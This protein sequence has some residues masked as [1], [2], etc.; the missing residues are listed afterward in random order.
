[1]LGESSHIHVEENTEDFVGNVGDGE[2]PAQSA[3]YTGFSLDAFTIEDPEGGADISGPA[4]SN[5][6]GIFLTS[7]SAQIEQSNTTGGF[8]WTA[9]TGGDADLSQILEEARSIH[10]VTNDVNSIEFDFTVDAGIVAVGADFVFGT[11]EYPEFTEYTDI[12]GFIV[13]G[14][15]YARF[16]DG[17]LVSF[18]EEGA[19]AN[20]INNDAGGY[21]IEYDGVSLQLRVCAPLDLARGTHH[22]KI[23][24][25]DTE[26]SS[27]DS[28]VFI[29][30]LR[31]GT[32]SSDENCGFV[33]PTAVGIHR[34]SDWAEAVD[35]WTYEVDE[36]EEHTIAFLA[37]ETAG[38]Q[39]LDV[40]DPGNIELLGSYAPPTCRDADGTEWLFYADEV[41][42]AEAQEAIH[43]SAGPCGVHVVEVA[44]AR[45]PDDLRPQEFDP[46]PNP[47]AVYAAHGAGV[48]GWVKAVE[49]RDGLAYVADYDALRIFDVSDLDHVRLRSSIART[50]PSF[51][52]GPVGNVVLY[53]DEAN[54]RLLALV[55]T[56]DGMRVVNVQDPDEPKVIGRYQ[57]DREHAISQDIALVPG[58]SYVLLP[59]W[60]A[61][62]SVVSIDDPSK[63]EEVTKRSQEE[64]PD[65]VA[66]YTAV[67]EGERIYATEGTRGLRVLE[68]VVPTSGQASLD[69]DPTDDPIAVG[70]PGQDWAWDLVVAD[71]T[72]YVTFGN[73][74]TG[75]GGLQVLKP[76][77][78]CESQNAEDEGG[79]VDEDLDGVA[80]AEDNCLGTAN[81]D[82]TDSDLDGFGNACDADYDGDGW[83]GISDYN[84]FSMSR[85][86]GAIAP[87]DRYDARFDHNADGG[88]GLQD[89][90]IFGKR[91]NAPPGPSGLACAG[92][93]P[94]P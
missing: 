39:I 69:P 16:A 24:I 4:I 44:N 82:Q 91:W 29:G 61:G 62:L 60:V 20:F 8:G 49:V 66:Y 67:S 21:A 58:T 31:G 93:V 79:Q 56:G 37:A 84:I 32:D 17:S 64:E 87:D 22:I 90:I 18:I 6:D 75:A 89:V 26:D 25:A 55:S 73:L 14:V 1:M 40:T 94:C 42:F 10:S 23:A 43:V 50:H 2:I 45:N 68:L 9:G 57:H 13:D 81:A 7:G 74:E 76:L 70:S 41:T 77:P 72:A 54:Q 85:A 71:C 48:D 86:Y 27:V 38:V 63:P 83:V 46:G 80:D 36:G 34:V 47:R 12:F 51:A 15:N 92:T 11:D 35:L 33:E 30:N 65:I 28:G 78:N 3:T 19:A 52:S 53:D 59:A 88:V 5:V